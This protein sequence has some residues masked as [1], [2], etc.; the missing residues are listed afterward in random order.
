MKFQI[1]NFKSNPKFIIGVVIMVLVAGALL[2]FLYYF[3]GSDGVPPANFFGIMNFIGGDSQESSEPFQEAPETANLRAGWKTE[4]NE[5]Y[6]FSFQ[7]PEDMKVGSVPSP[8]GT[9]T[10][11]VEKE[12][13][14]GFQIF[15]SPYDEPHLT[16]E[17]IKT[18]IPG[19]IMEQPQEVTVDGEQGVAFF[20][21]DDSIGKTREVWFVHKGYLY[22][23]TAYAEFSDKLFE[24][25]GTWKFNL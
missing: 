7:H 14:F 10:I 12:K 20:S 17:R 11:V 5:K 6:G 21:R 24:I 3:R 13:P 1:T 22:Q 19:I 18:N 16:V 25:L 8:E 15:I 9:E 4:T 23:I 2:G